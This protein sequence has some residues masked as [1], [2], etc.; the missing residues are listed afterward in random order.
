MT[1]VYHT[2]PL[3]PKAITC[4]PLNDTTI[5]NGWS[6]AQNKTYYKGDIIRFYCRSGFKVY[7]WSWRACYEKSDGTTGWSETTPRCEGMLF[8][9]RR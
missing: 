8:I 4:Q 1:S 7:G 5:D 2:P 6:D 3:N 9:I